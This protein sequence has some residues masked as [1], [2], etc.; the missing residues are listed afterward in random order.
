VSP[1]LY[2]LK[3]KETCKLQMFYWGEEVNLR[4][5]GEESENMKAVITITNQNG[6]GQRNTGRFW[7]LSNKLKRGD[8]STERS[9]GETRER[10]GFV[11]LRN[12]FKRDVC[13]YS[14]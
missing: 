9:S 7:D 12:Q 11:S 3:G 13:H 2:Q 8:E 6:S 14:P 5:G 4:K 10:N 1:V